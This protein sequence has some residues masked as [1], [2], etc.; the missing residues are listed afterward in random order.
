MSNEVP[1]IFLFHIPR[2]YVDPE[3]FHGSTLN[4]SGALELTGT[5][6]VHKKLKNGPPGGRILNPFQISFMGK[7]HDRGI[8]S[9]RNK[10]Y[11]A[12]AV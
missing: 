10:A 4:P 12:V 5:G 6:R 1:T 11:I 2:S 7:R 8:H 3:W 9:Q